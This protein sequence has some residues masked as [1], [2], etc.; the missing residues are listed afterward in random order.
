MLRGYSLELRSY[1]VILVVGTVSF[2]WTSSFGAIDP[3]T[4]SRLKGYTILL[5]R[6]KSLG[7]C[8]MCLIPT[9]I[10][11]ADIYLFRG[12][13]R[14]VVQRSGLQ[15]PM[16]ST[17]QGIVKDSGLVPLIFSFTFFSVYLLSI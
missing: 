11:R 2:R 12:R 3:N 7:L 13:I 14:Y 15:C 5:R 10:R 17:I 16:A 4:S 6:R 1:G 9:G 8:R